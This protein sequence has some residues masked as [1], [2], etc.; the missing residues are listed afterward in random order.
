[1]DGPAAGSF[2]ALEDCIDVF[3]VECGL[4]TLAPNQ[5]SRQL[6][7]LYGLHKVTESLEYSVALLVRNRH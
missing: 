4:A 1:M 5:V 2:V 7:K 3:E 6:R